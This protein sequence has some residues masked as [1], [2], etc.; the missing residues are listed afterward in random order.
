MRN[1]TITMLCVVF[2]GGCA[3]LLAPNKQ[4]TATDRLGCA[5]IDAP[6]ELTGKGKNVIVA[7]MH[8]TEQTA[9]LVR[10]LICSALAQGKQVS[11]ALEAPPMAV[12]IDRRT[13]LKSDFWKAEYADG[14]SSRAALDLLDRLAPA[15]RSGA[16]KVYGFAPTNV[17]VEGW[18]RQ[19]AQAITAGARS[20]DTLIVVTGNI[21]AR[22]GGTTSTLGDVLASATT[23]SILSNARGKIWACMPACGEHAL[24]PEASLSLGV[25]KA[26][27]RFGYDYAYVVNAYTAS[28]PA[29]GK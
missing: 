23:V 9:P 4:H 18:E 25:H 8:G 12:D 29:L 27:K 1:Q 21:H 26:P 15:R 16:V 3:H 20:G 24:G 28:P 2:L 7:E 10:D 5:D 6:A 13:A 11:L 19:A 14:R 22:R 17:G